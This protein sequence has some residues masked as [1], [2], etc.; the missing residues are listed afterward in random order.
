[1]ASKNLA[2]DLTG[3]ESGHPG[4]HN[5]IH[6][7]VNEFDY[8][9]LVAAANG[10]VVKKVG[11]IWTAGTDND[12]AA[13]GGA[14]IGLRY[15]DPQQPD[16]T[17][18]GF[19]QAT[20]KRDIQAAVDSLTS[21]GKVILAAHA[22]HV[23]GSTITDDGKNIEIEGLGKFATEVIV[24][25][26]Y[27]PIF[28]FTGRGSGIRHMRLRASDLTHAN[29][30]GALLQEKN[31]FV[32]DCTLWNIGAN[33]TTPYEVEDSDAPYGVKYMSPATTEATYPDTGG[34][35][36]ISD[37]VV[38]D[39]NYFFHTYRGICGLIGSNAI[40]T[41]NQGRMA[42]R[43]AGMYFQRGPALVEASAH[44]ADNFIV[45][46]SDDHPAGT[47]DSGY[48]VYIE[49]EAAGNPD[50]GWVR[51]VNTETESFGNGP[52]HYFADLT[53]C[54]WVG[55]VA[56]G[57]GGQQAVIEFGSVGN[58]GS[59]LV[60]PFTLGG[61][62]PNSYVNASAVRFVATQIGPP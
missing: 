4:L 47:R 19:T 45:G 20:A 17:G 32:T 49:K 55:C 62:T 29:I 54:Y 22:D 50:I 27:G 41:R 24:N 37:W 56:G 7:V 12:S 21:K 15:V 30:G 43:G 35:T 59:S 14:E 33:N 44:V 58:D 36:V 10:Q 31:C 6:E 13:G 57:T 38:I 51:F 11:G 5:D 34:S 40:I 2:T 28:Q 9:A 52:A 26:P 39:N 1:M 23:P 46:N 60:E 18:D 48:M 61:N 16:N 8:D 42:D 3:G 25:T 53:H